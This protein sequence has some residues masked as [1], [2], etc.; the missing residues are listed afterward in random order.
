MHTL[1]RSSFHLYHVSSWRALAGVAD[2]IAAVAAAAH[3]RRIA[4]LRAVTSERPSPEN[5]RGRLAR[6][7]PQ[8]DR[9]RPG[10]LARPDHAGA[11]IGLP[12]HRQPNSR[13]DQRGFF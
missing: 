7:I 3:R 1:T 5:S 6:R 10:G 13:G 8:P 12:K 4:M 2:A 9:G 11:V